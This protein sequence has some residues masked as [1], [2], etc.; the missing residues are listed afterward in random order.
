MVPSTNGCHVFCL[1]PI[2]EGDP[3]RFWVVLVRLNKFLAHCGVGSRRQ[4]DQ[5]VR[6]GK[7][8]VN[9]EVVLDPALDVD[10]D[11]D[12]VLYQGEYQELEEKVYYR[13]YK[14]EGQACTLEDPHIEH[15]LEPVVSQFAERVYPV[16]R[17]DQD[18]RGL[19]LLTNDGEI[20]HRISH[21]R[22]GVEKT[23]EVELDAAPSPSVVKIMSEKGVHLE[24]RQTIP[25]AIEP[26]DGS[27]LRIT[28]T[29]GRNRQIR[30]MFAKFDYEV[31]DL[32]RT[33]IGPLT[34]DG[35]APGEWSRLSEQEIKRLRKVVFEE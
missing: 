28:L 5:Y 18:S 10:P 15:T 3:Y 30:R 29:E 26:L 6:R 27:R 13:Y 17:L 1:R 20:S 19:L 23:Y 16:G 14:P 25:A 35:L 8:Q 32:I 12:V 11:R 31:Q 22:Y 2:P 21:P 33:R 7:V 24:G 9:G 34:L 4:C